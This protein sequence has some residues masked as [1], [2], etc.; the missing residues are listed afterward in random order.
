MPS[1]IAAAADVTATSSI[2]REFIVNS[3]GEDGYVEVKSSDTLA[4]VRQLI[5]Q[6]LDHE[7][8]PRK[9]SSSTSN[10]EGDDTSRCLPWPKKI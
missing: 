10:L 7:Q 6:E 4:D 8:L 5:I 2:M 3:Q 1:P 9:L